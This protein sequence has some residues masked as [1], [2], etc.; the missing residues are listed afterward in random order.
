MFT[1]TNSKRGTTTLN[2]LQYFQF[3]FSIY[4]CYE[5]YIL[6]TSLKA[7][8]FILYNN[9]LVYRND[10]LIRQLPVN[11][12]R[13]SFRFGIDRILRVLLVFVPIMATCTWNFTWT[14]IYLFETWG[15]CDVVGYYMGSASIIIVA[16]YYYFCFY[17]IVRFPT[18]KAF[19]DR[20]WTMIVLCYLVYW[21]ILIIRW[22]K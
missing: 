6:L 15:Y 13:T 7:F 1:R 10:V 14:I 17:V 3:Q 19:T 8:I 11:F 21:H 9:D 12:R 20:Q 5:N 16:L 22:V 18:I 2:T 4:L